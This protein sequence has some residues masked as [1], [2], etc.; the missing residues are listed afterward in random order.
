MHAFQRRA[1]SEPHHTRHCDRG[2]PYTNLDLPNIF[3][4]NGAD[5]QLRR[6]DLKF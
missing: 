5:R 4:S 6:K 3:E 1:K 2:G